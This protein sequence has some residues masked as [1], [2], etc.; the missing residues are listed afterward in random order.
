M[1]A[2]KEVSRLFGTELSIVERLQALPWKGYLQG[3][4]LTLILSVLARE[5][6]QFPFLSIMGAMVLSIL[7][8]MVWRGTMGLPTTAMLGVTF[9]SKWLLRAGII[10]MG[11]RLDIQQIVNAGL[12]VISI[13]TVVVLFT[14]LFMCWVGK[15]LKISR[16]ITILTAIGTA[17]CGAAAIVVIA[18]IIKAKKETTAV[19][20]SIIAVMGTVA[21]ILY[22]FV[23]P[24][25]PINNYLY[26]VLVGST[27]HELAHVIAAGDIGGEVSGKIAILVKLGRVALLIPAAFI[28]G[29]W[30]SR[31]EKSQSSTSAQDPTEKS[32][33]PIPYFIFGFLALSVVNSLGWLNVELTQW[34]ILLGVFLL[35]MAMAGLGLS[36]NTSHIKADGKKGF[37][38]CLIGTSALA[39]LGA[40]LINLLY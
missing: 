5:L 38:I 20:V 35:S 40:G 22:T 16:D 31:Q 4:T 29:Y 27:L 26:G 25:L 8:G 18:P 13:D 21:T 39:L 10:L 19:A 15:W 14:F 1:Q 34:L 32:K 6:V 9:S 12:H 2:Q 7:L 17:V 36:V 37:L 28:I 30:F 33:M 11:L 23:Y 3:I 24:L